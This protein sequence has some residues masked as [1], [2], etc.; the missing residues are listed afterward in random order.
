MD[1]AIHEPQQNAKTMGPPVTPRSERPRSALIN[2][3]SSARPISPPSAP[4]LVT[5]VSPRSPPNKSTHL[6]HASSVPHLPIP[7]YTSPNGLGSRPAP[8]V[9]PH[10]TRPINQPS[11]QIP[12]SAEPRESRAP[13]KSP[14]LVPKYNTGSIVDTPLAI[15]PPPVSR[16]DKPKVPL[17][18]PN[19]KKLSILE[20]SAAVND[21]RISPF[22]TPPSSDESPNQIS[23]MPASKISQSK[24]TNNPRE[25]GV[26]P[27]SP[28][29][30]PEVIQESNTVSGPTSYPQITRTHG[31]RKSIGYTEEVRPGLPPRRTTEQGPQPQSLRAHEGR[32]AST[33]RIGRQV[34]QPVPVNQVTPSSASRVVPLPSRFLPPP[35]RN[36][37]SD[38]FE[39]SQPPSQIPSPM[40]DP[41]DTS[42]STDHAIDLASSAVNKVEFPDASQ[43]NRRPPATRHGIHEI[44]TNYDT[45]LFD[46]CG[47][48]LCTTG[49]LTR[50]WNLST[51]SAIMNLGH[52]EQTKVTA[53]AFKPGATAEEEGL[54]LWM[55]TNFGDLYEVDIPTQ[56]VISTKSSAHSRREVVKI[57]RC[58]NSIWTL[59]DGGNLHVWPPEKSGLPNLLGNAVLRRVPKGHTYSMVI[60]R[61]LWLAT[62]KEIRIFNPGS[63]SDAE[64][65]LTSQPLTQ[66]NVGEVTSGAVIS[67]QHDRVYF[68]HTDGKV[69]MY[70]TSNFSCMGIVNV[71][72]YKISALAGAG[73]YLWA[74]Y[75]TGMIYVYDTR[76]TPWR[77]KKDWHAHTNPV[78][79]ILVDRSSVWKSGVLQV[80]SIGT[81]N[82]VRIWDGMLEEDW[83]G[84]C[85]MTEVL[86]LCILTV[87]RG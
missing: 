12:K 11:V 30:A 67:S 72:V 73:D 71:S 76:M 39:L 15:P 64:F 54:R 48:Y 43:T 7:K 14:M 21:E 20:P 37:T 41:N 74:G 82:A 42:V 59:D 63:S 34:S 5:V 47:D 29:A 80:A 18:P 2:R 78:A 61:R 38:D 56:S 17:K 28:P 10:F 25:K 19:R 26:S 44:D 16:A 65:Q 50:A 57:H 22:S 62:G 55:G 35:K 52:G 68:G 13:V 9:P 40:P 66:Q 83:L 32:V 79:S 45:R 24:T 86:V 51:G 81:D 1:A 58:Q 53:V 27:F 31:P 4:P 6:S 36:G 84:E 60:H 75:S 77:T 49:Y 70:S 3:P 85:H 33:S 23:T 69:T 8:P 87:I 46:F